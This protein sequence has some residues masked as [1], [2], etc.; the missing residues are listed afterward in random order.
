MLFG[1]NFDR[2]TLYIIMGIMALL[3]LFSLSS[4]SILSTILTLPGVIIAISCHEF[5]HAWMA[6]KLGDPTARNMGRMT[7][8]PRSHLN[9]IG[10]VLLIFT[11]IGWGEPV[12]VNTNNFTKVS[13]KTG[14][15]LV[16]L[17]G[18]VMNFILAIIF[19]IMLYLISVFSPY[20]IL[21]MIFA[22]EIAGMSFMGLV[23]LTVYCAITV[24]IGL[25]VFNLI[26]I[27][28]LDGS[29]IFLQFL[30]YNAQRWLDEKQGIIYLVFII[31]WISGILGY[32]VAYPI[33]WIQNFIFNIV[34]AVFSL[35]L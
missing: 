5:A 6:N 28:P 16:S 32:I 24:N 26:P 19:T 10:F 29:K 30:P 8:D 34:G 31:L 9:P 20:A 33:S 15:I 1:Y 2:K 25:G 21:D 14:E 35:F 27:P 18:P 4:F 12:P 7:L 17:A 13:R 11:H 3:L 23:A 22:Q